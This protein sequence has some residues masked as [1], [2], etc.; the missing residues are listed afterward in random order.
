VNRAAGAV[1]AALFAASVTPPAGAERQ[2]PDAGRK[3]AATPGARRARP[4]LDFSGTWVLDE[5]ASGGVAPAMSEAVV[6]VRQT[7]NQIWISPEDPSDSHLLAESIV[8]DGRPYEKT[9]GNKG[10]GTLTVAWGKDGKS[11][12]LEMTAGPEENPRASMQRSVWKLS[13]DR[14]TWIRQSVSVD[15]KK[16]R[17]SRL[18]FRR[19]K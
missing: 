17:Q 13:P 2:A 16:V 5:Q 14:N 12:W 19:R 11:L 7:G 15:G 6:T 8:A 3:P 4:P 18:V 9:L 10:R 1:L